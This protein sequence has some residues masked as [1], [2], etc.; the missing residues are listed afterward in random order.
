MW[1]K[2]MGKLADDSEAAEHPSE[3]AEHPEQSVSTLWRTGACCCHC[4]PASCSLLGGVV[5]LVLGAIVLFVWS[6]V[7]RHYVGIGVAAAAAMIV[8]PSICVYLKKLRHRRPLP[9]QLLWCLTL[10]LVIILLLVRLACARPP[11]V[12]TGVFPPDCYATWYG[13][14]PRDCVRV[15]PGATSQQLAGVVANASEP[16]FA[17]RLPAS[18]VSAAVYEWASSLFQTSVI[19]TER[20]VLHALVRPSAIS[21]HSL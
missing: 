12:E 5:A 14:T 6:I 1:Q 9:W 11:P 16:L 8:A 7:V 13:A 2:A 10:A 19:S 4:C 20:D 21:P 18:A 17:K 3:A 15:A